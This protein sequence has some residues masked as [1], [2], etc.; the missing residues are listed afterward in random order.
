MQVDS[1]VYHISLTRAE[2]RMLRELVAEAASEFNWSD[3]DY[4][5][6]DLQEEWEVLESLLEGFGLERPLSA[7][8]G[9]DDVGEDS[10]GVQQ[11]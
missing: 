9:E 11:G 6:R 8:E 1:I 10:G 5:S 3:W 2:Y 4:G 7:E